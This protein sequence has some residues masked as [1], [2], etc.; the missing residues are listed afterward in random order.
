MHDLYFIRHGKTRANEHGILAGRTDH[1]VLPEAKT[2]LCRLAHEY[3]YPVAMAFYR[4]PLQRCWQTLNCLYPGVEAQ[5]VDDLIEIDFGEYE[6]KHAPGIIRKIGVD[7]FANRELTI[8]FPSG[9][10]ISDCLVRGH[11]AVDIILTDLQQKG[12]TS[13]VIITHSMFISIFLKYCSSEK[14]DKGHLFC[15]NGMGV[16]VRVTPTVWRESR[17]VNLVGLLPHN[18]PR[19]QLVDSPYSAY[20]VTSN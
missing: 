9:E 18:A 16:H 1:P 8:C 7:R 4:S 15:P 14:L 10:S 17:M 2:E 11:R 19:E 12:T 5:I 20:G 3:T 13:A 6:G